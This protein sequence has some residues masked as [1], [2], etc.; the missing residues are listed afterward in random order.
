MIRSLKYLTYAV[1]LASAL[2]AAGC[3]S[4]PSEEEMKQLNDLKAQASAL[5]KQVADKTR[6]KALL[7]RQIAE[8]NGKI[9][10]CQSDQEAVKKALGAK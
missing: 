8:K 9:Q 4:S 7:E 10:Q 5:D 3:S 2:F 1:V 6:E